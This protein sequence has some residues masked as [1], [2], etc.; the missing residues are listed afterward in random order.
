MS[1]AYC[2]TDHSDKSAEWSHAEPE[3]RRLFTNCGHSRRYGPGET[4][5]LQGDGNRGVYYLESGLVALRRSDEN[6]NSA[7]VC[8]NHPDDLIGYPAFLSQ[9]EHRN[10]AEVLTPSKIY[11]IDASRLR[12]MLNS[13]PNLKES[14]LER[15]L[16]DL[17]RAEANCAALLTADLRCRLFH[18]LL[19]FSKSYG[20][21]LSDGSPGVEL[22]VQRK[23][24]AAL[25]GAKPE[26]ISRLI[27]ML[28]QE[29]LVRFKGRLVAISSLNRL[30]A[31]VSIFN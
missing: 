11:F 5:F 25:L 20:T 4:L 15:A 26:S 8:L 19:T 10:T 14:F 21:Q 12:W 16:L 28:D 6:G 13:D 9:K 27:R 22:P 3:Y 24:L 18:L 1:C 29:G 31:E 7:L 17:D 23:D 30:A 2:R